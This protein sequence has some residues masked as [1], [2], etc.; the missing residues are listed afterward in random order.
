MN[1]PI[2]DLKEQYQSIKSEINEAVGK[3]LGETQFILGPEVKKLEEEIAEFIGTKY[4]VGVASGTDAL[5]LALRAMGVGKGDEV[6]TTPF[7]F[8]AT[9]ETVLLAGAVPVFA[10]INP[11]TFNIDPESIEKKLTSKTKAIIPV[12]LYG[13]CADMDKI[14]N[15]ARK[16]NLKVLEDC[17]QSFGAEFK[18]KKAGSFG[19]TSAFSFFPTKNLGCFGDGGMVLTNSEEV[20]ENLKMLRGHGSKVR[21]YHDIEGFNSRLDTL[22]AAILRVKLKYI[23][24]WNEKRRNAAHLYNKLIKDSGVKTPVESGEGKH[25]YHQYTIKCKKRNELKDFLAGA[26][27]TSMIYYPLSL[28]QQ[29]V[30]ECLGYKKGDFPRSEKVQDEVLSLPIFPELG[31]ERIKII[32][33]KI[34]EFYR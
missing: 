21:Y 2:L 14:M 33:E 11:D 29:K 19:D 3:V 31:E 23:N 18:G 30:F 25:V 5:H 26:G 22:Q 10:D 24:E 1:I 20:A 8:I 6:I 27:I 12:H 17:A 9:A 13:Q 15:I 32:S 34:N 4:A 7:T 16:H 28:H